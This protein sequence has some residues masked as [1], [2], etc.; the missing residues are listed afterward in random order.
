[1]VDY[2]EVS[3]HNK[4]KINRSKISTYNISL[5]IRL[6]V[7]IGLLFNVINVIVNHRFSKFLRGLN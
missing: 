5:N 4:I 2:L 3:K 6:S 1:M 7:K